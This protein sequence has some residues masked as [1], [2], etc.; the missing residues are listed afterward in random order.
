MKNHIFPFLAI[1]KNRRLFIILT[2]KYK[3]KSKNVHLANF[4]TYMTKY[5]FRVSLQA[6]LLY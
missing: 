5:N 6:I 1:M 2:M 4:T 3:N